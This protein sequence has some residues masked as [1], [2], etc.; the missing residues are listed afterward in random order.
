MNK[1]ELWECTIESLHQL[2]FHLLFFTAITVCYAG[3]FSALFDEDC[4]P[5]VEFS[6]LHGH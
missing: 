6:K 4:Q 3:A 5:T 2:Q 1:N